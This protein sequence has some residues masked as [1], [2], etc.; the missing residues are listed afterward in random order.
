MF[1]GR[2][3]CHY[4]SKGFLL[5]LTP[6][7]IKTWWNNKQFLGCKRL[8]KGMNTRIGDHWGTSWV[9]WPQESMIIPISQ[10]SKIEA[11][12]GKSV[13][14]ETHSWCLAELGFE[15][16]SHWL[17]HHAEATLKPEL[18]LGEKVGGI[19]TSTLG[20]NALTGFMFY[21]LVIQTSHLT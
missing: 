14:P 13:V 12:E 10:E 8:Y 7:E 4:F 17:Q 6:K 9:W 20:H 15:T 5:I 1:K 11:Q 16:W 21:S 3:L 19:S 18:R 2:N